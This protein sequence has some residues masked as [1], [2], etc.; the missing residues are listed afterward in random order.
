MMRTIGKYNLEQVKAELE[1]FILQD[2]LRMRLA[3]S[4]T[5]SPYYIPYHPG[6]PVGVLRE[7]YHNAL[8]SSSFPYD[9]HTVEAW[10]RRGET[11]QVRCI[12]AGNLKMAGTQQ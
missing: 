7:T 9:P 3:N 12:S 10:L 4:V 8:V 6:H 2:S 5:L 1:I 11:F